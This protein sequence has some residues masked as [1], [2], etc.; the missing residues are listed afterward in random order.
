MPKIRYQA[1]ENKRVGT[2]SFYAQAIATGKLSFRE[3]CEEACEDN[4]YSIE[5]MTGCVSRFMKTIQ[6]EALRGWRC[7]LGEDF[8]TIFPQIDA[9][10]KDYTDPET[11]QL[12]VATAEMLTA[13]NAHS[14]LGCSVHKKFS[15]K[16][17]TEVQ[18]QK[19]DANGNEISDDEE[20]ITQN[21][22][23]PTPDPNEGGENEE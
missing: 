4:T 9:S 22:D 20:D 11:G 21:N 16:F 12:V 15:A 19:V 10:V 17:A 3:L 13:N 8:L 18:W 2:H 1:K 6:R 23:G 7:Q 5:E 14:R